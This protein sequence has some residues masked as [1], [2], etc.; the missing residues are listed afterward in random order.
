MLMIPS[1]GTRTTE[2]PT[3]PGRLPILSRM[4]PMLNRFISPTWTVTAILTLF[5]DRRA[6]IPSRGTRTMEQPIH[7][8]QPSIFRPHMMPV[9]CSWLTW[10]VTVM[11]TLFQHPTM[12][13]PSRFLNKKEHDS[14]TPQLTAPLLILQEST[15]PQSPLVISMLAPSQDP[16]FH[17]G[18]R[19]PLALL[20]MA[21]QE[22]LIRLLLSQWLLRLDGFRLM[23]LLIMTVLVQCTVMLQTQNASIVG[24]TFT[25]SATVISC[26]VILMNRTI[27]FIGIHQ[28]AEFPLILVTQVLN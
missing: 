11:L 20:V 24:V 27:L 26:A 2:Q 1:H 12:T 16:A 5:Q 25:W 7:R 28:Q 4:L 19:K 22:P 18:A 17:A 8:G 9:M 13:T 3:H 14:C 10:I 6:T 21:P 15:T 23:S